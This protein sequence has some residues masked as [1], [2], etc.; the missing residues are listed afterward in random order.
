M[1][2]KDREAKKANKA[3]NRKAAKEE[4]QM[5]KDMQVAQGAALKNEMEKSGKKVAVE[6]VSTDE[7]YMKTTVMNTDSINDQMQ[8][9]SKGERKMQ[10]GRG[11]D[12]TS[13]LPDAVE[14]KPAAKKDGTATKDSTATTGT[15]AK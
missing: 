8:T 9:D 13:K 1:T 12:A 5:F 11:K 3:A 2:K 14:E 4:L 15:D 10:I 6:E 7:T